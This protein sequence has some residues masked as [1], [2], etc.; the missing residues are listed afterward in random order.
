MIVK[1]VY[2]KKLSLDDFKTK[3]KWLKLFIEY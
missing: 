1:K 2:S 3:K